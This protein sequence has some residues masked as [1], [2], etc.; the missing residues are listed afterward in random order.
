M[1][2]ATNPLL[3]LKKARAE[4]ERMREAGAWWERRADQLKKANTHLVSRVAQL[5]AEVSTLREIINPTAP[6]P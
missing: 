2:D 4:L 1:A 3:E 6:K 5:E